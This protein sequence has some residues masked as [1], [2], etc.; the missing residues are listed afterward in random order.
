MTCS[1]ITGGGGG[2]R[3]P[4]SSLGG[5]ITRHTRIVVDI[6]VTR[7]QTK[8]LLSSVQQ[9]ATSLLSLLARYTQSIAATG[10]ASLS[11][12]LPRKILLYGPAGHGKRSL[13]H[14]V[15]TKSA[16]P[17]ITVSPADV[18]AKAMQTTNPIESLFHDTKKQQPCI[19]T[20][21]SIIILSTRCAC[22]TVRRCSIVGQCLHAVM[23]EDADVLLAEDELGQLESQTAIIAQFTEVVR[24]FNQPG[25][26]FIA[27]ASDV[28]VLPLSIRHLFDVRYL[29]MLKTHL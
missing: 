14:V 3:A 19:R 23:F 24:G 26:L 16:V 2:G 5:V 18:S 13:V 21:S 7:K 9:E 27:T 4:P 10:A 8:D 1:I 22:L 15:A 20:S 29:L 11:L 17:L 25:V 6:P 12:E 28:D